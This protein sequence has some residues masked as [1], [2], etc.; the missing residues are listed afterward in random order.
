ML[1]NILGLE[2]SGSEISQKPDPG[3]VVPHSAKLRVSDVP[4]LTHILV[5]GRCSGKH[6]HF[7]LPFQ[8]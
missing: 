8:I 3:I 7:L 6:F 1:K 4:E 5:F 2:P